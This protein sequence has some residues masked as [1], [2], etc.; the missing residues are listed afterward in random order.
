MNNWRVPKKGFA[1]VWRKPA[2]AAELSLPERVLAEQLAA[3]PRASLPNEQ[4][5][6][7]QLTDAAAE[8]AAPAR[9]LEL[10]KRSPF[11]FGDF[12][13]PDL[14]ATFESAMPVALPRHG[15]QPTLERSPRKKGR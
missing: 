1:V 11:D 15:A 9:L 12:D 6:M 7:E 10:P 14:D 5:P 3:A 8:A 4:P 13:A 2:N